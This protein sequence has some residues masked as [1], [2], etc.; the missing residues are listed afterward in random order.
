MR[1]GGG[2][3]VGVFEAVAV[4]FEADEFGV[5]DES[6][7]HRGG[8]RV[9]AEDLT[10][11]ADGLV[12]GDDQAGALIAAADE[13]EHQAV[14][15]GVK[16][17]VSHFVADQ[18]RDPLE[19]VELLVEPVGVLGLAESSTHSVAVRNRTRWPARH[20]RTPRAMEMWVFP[21]P[22][23][24]EDDVR[25]GVQEV[26]LAEVLDHVLF[27]R[28]LEGEVKL[29]SVLWAGNRED[30]RLSV[31]HLARNSHLRASSSLSTPRA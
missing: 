14:G 12:A 21:V 3:E 13:H 6:V 17:Y 22:G 4:A 23:S 28:A 10:P 11:G 5:V 19:A 2:S 26:Q 18:Q 30:I 15:L 20:A 16:R 31:P 29:L 9:V 27:D 1:V 25:F 8:G 24:E 7:D